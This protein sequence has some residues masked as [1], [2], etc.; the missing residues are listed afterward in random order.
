MNVADYIIRS[1]I[2]NKKPISNLQ[3]QKISYFLNV[4]SLISHD[5]GLIDDEHFSKWK[6]GPVLPDVYSEYSTYGAEVIAKVKEHETVD[7]DNDGKIIFDTYTFN[8]EEDLDL[9]ERKLINNNIK[10]FL[11]YDP[12]YLVEES[13]KEDQYSDHTTPEY[14]DDKTIDYYSQRRNQFWLDNHDS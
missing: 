11:D 8:S 6:Y 12:F 10:L 1:A 4:I 2:R 7:I 9:N 14:S 13:H 5:V 3:L